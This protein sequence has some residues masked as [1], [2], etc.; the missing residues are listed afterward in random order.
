MSLSS[1]GQL[2]QQGLMVFVLVL[3]LVSVKNK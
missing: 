1:R 3:V 2:S